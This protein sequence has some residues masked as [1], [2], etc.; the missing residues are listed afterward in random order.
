MEMPLNPIVK[1]SLEPSTPGKNDYWWG[2]I[3]GTNQ[4]CHIWG[5]VDNPDKGYEAATK[6]YNAAREEILNPKPKEAPD[7]NFYWITEVE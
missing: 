3:D 2:V 4:N 6:A 7:Y 1:I 5:F